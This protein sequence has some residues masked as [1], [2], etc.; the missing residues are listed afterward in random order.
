MHMPDEAPSKSSTLI[1]IVVLVYNIAPYL[2][3]C[4]QSVLSQTHENMQIII[5]NDGSTDASSSKCRDYAE[6]DARILLIEQENGG[7]SRARNT[8]MDH[9]L[10]E[11]ICF[12]DGDDY[13]EATYLERLVEATER[14]S[15]DVAVCGYYFEKDTCAGNDADATD[16]IDKEIRFAEG[17][18]NEHGFWR[19][20]MNTNTLNVYV[21]NKLYK[22]SAIGNIQFIAGKSCQDQPFNMEVIARADQVCFVAEPLYHYVYRNNSV[23]TVASFSTNL[24]ACEFDMMLCDHLEERGYYDCI[25]SVLHRTINRLARRH[26]REDDAAQKELYDTICDY[27][28][29]QYH[30]EVQRGS[31][32]KSLRLKYRCFKLFGGRGYLFLSRVYQKFSGGE[33]R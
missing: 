3:R 27:F 31:L 19:T 22:R 18:C 7:V 16:F 9:A 23:T 33:D 32:S 17:V 21:W 4:M 26:P 2:D 1:T 10:G 15:A 5:V 14:T 13:L 6:K 29:R 25:P 20:A 24:D 28:D 30:K 8:G 12:I 11:Y